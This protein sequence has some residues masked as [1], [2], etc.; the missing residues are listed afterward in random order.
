MAQAN[1]LGFVPTDGSLVTTV[2]VHMS[3]NFVHHAGGS[4]YRELPQAEPAITGAGCR[5]NAVTAIVRE[6]THRMPATYPPAL[7]E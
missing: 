7:V 1:R 6:A 3:E 4:P 5:A 2:A